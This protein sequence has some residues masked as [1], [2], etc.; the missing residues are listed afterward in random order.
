MAND[1]RQKEK[2]RKRLG[3]E[4]QEFIDF[5]EETLRLFGEDRLD[6]DSRFLFKQDAED[7]YRR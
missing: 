1:E 4:K 5:S 2:Y 7:I 3:M 6:T